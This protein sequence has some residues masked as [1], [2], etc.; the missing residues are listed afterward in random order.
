MTH[1]T[2]S[3]NVF[4]LPPPDPQQPWRRWIDTYRDAP[5]DV[6]EWSAA[7]AVDGTSYTVQPRSFV[8]LFAE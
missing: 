4:E 6:H 7:P 5:D 2:M 1:V 8:T 3:A